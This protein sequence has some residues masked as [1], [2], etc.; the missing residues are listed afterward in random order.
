MGTERTHQ[1]LELAAECPP[2]D[3]QKHI[4][5]LIGLLRG[6]METDYASSRMLRDAHPKMHGCVRA[7]FRVEAG[8]PP[9]LGIGVFSAPRIF[10]AWVRFSNAGSSVA[11][12]WNKDIRG[13]AIK[14][15]GVDGEKLFD[16]ETPEKTQDFLLISSDRFLTKDVAQ[17]DGFVRNLEK[18]LLCLIWFLLTHLRV[19][20]NL[21]NSMRR[22]ANLFEIRYY[23]VTPY[24]LGTRVVKYSLRQP[25]AAESSLPKNPSSDYLRET[26]IRQLKSGTVTLDFMVQFQSD[27]RTMPIEDVSF[28]WDETV[29][30]FIKVATLTIGVQDFDSE[31]QREFGDNLS[32]NPWRCLPEHRPLGGMNRARH[33]VYPTLSA[34]RHQR[35]GA[36]QHEP[37]PDEMP[38]V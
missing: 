1:G 22:F 24:L 34:F 29:S 12:D 31:A 16:D 6:K 7:E 25:G 17:F 3:E 36:V 38:G 14:L 23:S 13:V 37:T 9:E 20:R 30:P 28:A 4:D 10:P 32:F 21:Y 2:P 18:G 26:M 15:M 11:P 5:S 19:A 27:P 35:N 33:Q 8:L